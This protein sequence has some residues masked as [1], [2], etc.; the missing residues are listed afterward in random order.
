MDF[1]VIDKDNFKIFSPIIFDA[2]TDDSKEVLRIGA[3][4]DN[5]IIGPPS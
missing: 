2:F 3:V 5:N 1:T 4:E